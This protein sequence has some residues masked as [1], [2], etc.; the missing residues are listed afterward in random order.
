MYEIVA[1]FYDLT[2][3][4]LTEDIELIVA[5]A[6]TS[7]EPVLELGCGTGRLLVPLARAGNVVTGVDNSAAM[8]TRAHGRISAE[9]AD[10]AS[11]IT[12]IEGD[13]T[14]LE[15]VVGSFGLIV[16]PYNTLLHLSPPDQLRTFQQALSKLSP[17]GQM[18]IDLANPFDLLGV[19]SETEFEPEATLTDPDTGL[20]VVQWSRMRANEEAQQLTIEWRYVTAGEEVWAVSAEYHV[21]YPHQLEMQLQRAG[22]RLMALWGGYDQQPFEADSE[23]MLLLV[24]AA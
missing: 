18:L 4:A 14:R 9:S 16:I 23:R 3:D 5:L 21:Q 11:R 19:A 2:H 8:L 17:T 15:G 10:V 20:E 22:L 1:R 24:S 12:L 13:M 6:Q 7:A